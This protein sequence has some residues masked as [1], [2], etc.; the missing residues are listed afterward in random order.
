MRTLLRTLKQR[1]HYVLIDTPE[2]AITS[3]ASLLGA[4]VDGVIVVVRLSSTPRG[5]VEQ[6]CRSLEALGCNVLGT[7]LT[8]ALV[9]DT[10]QH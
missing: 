7:C 4:M 6:T 5:Y 10:A 8:G 1:F 9:P 3:D 2:A